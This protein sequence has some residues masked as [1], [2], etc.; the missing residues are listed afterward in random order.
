VTGPDLTVADLPGS[1]PAGLRTAVLRD[2]ECWRFDAADPATWDWRPF[3]T[4]R[5]RFD[6]AGG[7]ARIRY[8]GLTARG[9]SRERWAPD[10]RIALV[11]ARTWVV[12][13]AGTLRVIDLRRESVV[14][15][16][17][18][19]HR[20]NTA[21]DPA[22]WRV[23]Q[24]LGDRLRQWMPSLGAIVY[25]SRTTPETSANVA[26][27][28]PGALRVVSATPLRECPDLL[29]RLVLADG[30]AVSFDW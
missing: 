29:D 19:D 26:W 9:A 18:L 21:R 4:P 6:S 2:I 15:R 28:R 13:L 17:G 11:D 20:I 10:R 5:Y 3:P 27:H 12:R 7:T 22:I 1:R 8:A 25:R 30:F 14:D 23:C 16:L 24:V